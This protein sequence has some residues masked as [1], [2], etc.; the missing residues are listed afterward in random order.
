MD[1]GDSYYAE[2]YKEVKLAYLASE[3]VT[4]LETDTRKGWGEGD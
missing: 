3:D 4:L 1:G 2:P